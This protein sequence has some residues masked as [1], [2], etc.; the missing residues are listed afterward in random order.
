M[1]YADPIPSALD[2]Y[3][4]LFRRTA[5]DNLLSKAGLA[6]KAAMMARELSCTVSLSRGEPNTLVPVDAEGEYPTVGTEVG[7][8]A[9]IVSEV[10]TRKGYTVTQGALAISVSW[11]QGF[12]VLN[13]EPLSLT[14][15]PLDKPRVDPYGADTPE[16][17]QTTE[18]DLPHLLDAVQTLQARMKVYQVQEASQLA[19]IPKAGLSDMQLA[20]VG[21][22]LSMYRYSAALGLWLGEQLLFSSAEDYVKSTE[23]LGSVFMIPPGSNVLITLVLS[24]AEDVDVSGV[25]GQDDKGIVLL[26][27]YDEDGGK[28]AKPLPNSVTPIEIP[29]SATSRSLSTA[30]IMPLLGGALPILTPG[31]YAVRRS[32]AYPSTTI[33]QGQIILIG[34]PVVVYGP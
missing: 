10:L 13:S 14:S 31:R 11:D 1:S 8:V 26:Q 3:A 4:S 6:I 21:G 25:S 32:S 28:S 30:D 34:R 12:P 33:R 2:A 15:I 29:I 16:D 9:S 18:T 22:G 20:T 23:A 7:V 19:L 27:K 17:T 5:A 24:G